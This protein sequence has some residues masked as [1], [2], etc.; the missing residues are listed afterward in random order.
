VRYL[1]DT[2]VL[3]DFARGDPRTLANVKQTPPTDIAVSTLTAMEIDFGLAL[4]PIRARALGPILRGLID[5]VSVLSYE[6]ED[7]R[8]N[9]VLRAALQRRGR[10]IGA[11][12]ALLAGCAIARGLVLVTANEK[13]YSRVSGLKLENWREA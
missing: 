11:Y 9:A 6:I 4:D 8:A 7:A 12:D 3:S 13:E 2:C 1:L 10:P 5:A